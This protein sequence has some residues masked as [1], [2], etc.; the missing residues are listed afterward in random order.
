MHIRR[1]IYSS[2]VALM[3][4]FYHSKLQLLFQ[5]K[6][7]HT[8][9]C[10]LTAP[11][12]QLPP[13]TCWFHLVSHQSHQWLP[14]GNLGRQ[15]GEEGEPASGEGH[16]FGRTI[17]IPCLSWS[18]WGG[19]TSHRRDHFILKFGHGSD[20]CTPG[21]APTKEFQMSGLL[22]ITLV[23][24]GHPFWRSL[25]SNPTATLSPTGKRVWCGENV[26]WLQIWMKTELESQYTL[27]LIEAGFPAGTELDG[28]V[29]HL[30]RHFP[31]RPEAWT[32]CLSF[33]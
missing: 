16:G 2:W 19:G 17:V 9:P 13:H 3:T 21:W 25:I 18:S 6:Q 15:A 20:D 27:V 30:S 26:H 11:S 24:T 22:L 28:S 4:W 32:P 29:I 12:R 31:P 8:L 33:L 1:R 7:M 23:N 10:R 14:S 5:R